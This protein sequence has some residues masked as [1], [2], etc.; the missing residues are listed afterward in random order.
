MVPGWLIQQ[1]IHVIFLL[2]HPKQLQTTYPY[3]QCSEAHGRDPQRIL[4]SFNREGRG[5]RLQVKQPTAAAHV[6]TMKSKLKENLVFCLVLVLFIHYETPVTYTKDIKS[7]NN[8]KVPKR[9]G[10]I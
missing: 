2:Y 10:V 7:C 3:P 4:E 1:P 6:M 8:F 5:E 9:Y